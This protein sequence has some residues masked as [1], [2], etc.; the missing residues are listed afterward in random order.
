M[1]NTHYY[2][3]IEDHIPQAAE[4]R[5]IR[6]I[7]ADYGAEILY[8][9]EI[10]ISVNIHKDMIEASGDKEKNRFRIRIRYSEQ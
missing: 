10:D 6:E 9:E 2:D 5:S 7:E 3:L 4:G 8:G 1:N